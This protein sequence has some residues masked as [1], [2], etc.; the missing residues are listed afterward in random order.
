[1]SNH[2]IKN[3][4]IIGLTS[5][6]IGA[7]EHTNI[8]NFLIIDPL[9]K[10]LRKS[11]PKINIK[12]SLQL[13]EEFAEKYGLTILRN[14]RFWT[15]KLFTLAS[16]LIDFLR[17][18]IYRIYKLFGVENRKI[19]DNSILLKEISSADI[20]LD[21]SGDLFGDNAPI[22]RFIEGSAKLLFASYLEKPVIMIASSPGP[23]EKNFFYKWLG[24]LV[25]KKVTL[26]LNREPTSTDYLIKIGVN[27]EKIINSACPSF[28]FD[29][30]SEKSVEELLGSE[31]INFVKPS[32]GIVITGW[33]MPTPPF[34]KIPRK[35][36]ELIKFI[37][38]IDYFLDQNIQ[39]F[40]IPHSYRLDKQG[41]VIPGP[42]SVICEQLYGLVENNNKL[43]YLRIIRGVYKPEEMRKIIG[44]LD[45]LVS[46]RLHAA[47]S[48]LSQGVPTVIIDY[49]F[50][51]RGH[52]LLG[53][54]KLMAIE[55]LFSDPNTRGDMLEKVKKG[56]QNKSFYEEK[57]TTQLKTV[58]LAARMNF[59]I[60]KSYLGENEIN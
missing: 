1:M 57:I 58:K 50:E 28:L 29:M 12:T 60:L 47:I 30:D 52:K 23:F 49:G 44:S 43:K 6:K 18:C 35:N 40:L 21:F 9:F 2:E 42:D 31:G 4:L 8:G 51:P 59:D 54:S 10:N 36:E 53:V 25:L 32:V 19:L 45:F 56:W 48:G 26:I 20:V 37:P 41:G 11:F 15:Y 14:R 3:V 22:Q 24:K 27:K 38:I 17:I 7:L 34:D 46:G 13:S 16:S 33:N 5:V 39:V 55:D